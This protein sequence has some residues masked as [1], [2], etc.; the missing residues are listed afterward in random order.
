MPSAMPV[1]DLYD[2]ALS[3]KFTK[4]VFVN[5]RGDR[6]EGFVR[7]DF[8]FQVTSRFQ[9]AF[10]SETMGRLSHKINSVTGMLGAAVGSRITQIQVKHAAMTVLAWEGTDKPSFS[11]NLLF[12]AYKSTIDVLTQVKTLLKGVFPE[13]ALGKGIF[14]APLEYNAM[15]VGGAVGCWT[16]AIGQWF[17]APFQ[18]FT[19]VSPRISK[20]VV[21]GG[22]PLY[23]EV[24]VSFE[25]YRMINWKEFQTYFREPVADSAGVIQHVKPSDDFFQRV[26]SGYD[27][28][29]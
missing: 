28:E 1:L 16:V 23:A 6:V 17:F 18:L 21:S 14:K 10:D 29:S 3:N 8:N 9:A 11:L 20:E 26:W 25:P 27:T 5:D 15:G 12:V 13:T 7:D 22:K 24:G 4:I 2:K 19:T